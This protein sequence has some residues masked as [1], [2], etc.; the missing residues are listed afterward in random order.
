MR[1]TV[2]LFASALCPLPS[3]LCPLP[4]ASCLLP[5]RNC[6]L[7]SL[8][9]VLLC[10]NVTYGGQPLLCHGLLTLVIVSVERR[11]T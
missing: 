9:T 7:L 6:T 10:L 2:L 3:A 1:K 11:S 4:S 8:G 5:L